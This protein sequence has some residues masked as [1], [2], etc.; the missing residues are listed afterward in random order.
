MVA[1]ALGVLHP[2]RETA[3]L[4]KL[5]SAQIK[6]LLINA[7]QTDLVRVFSGLNDQ[8]NYG[9]NVL[10]TRDNPA[11]VR[12]ER[13]PFPPVL[14]QFRVGKCRAVFLKLLDVH[15]RTPFK[16]ATE[17]GAATVQR[18]RIVA[19]L[20]T[21]IPASPRKH[22]STKKDRVNPPSNFSRFPLW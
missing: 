21:A 13:D 14:E 15:D 8:L 19:R 11:S 20:S 9:A 22:K 16:V 18:S 3:S 6:V 4:E 5:R 10:M 12:A 2:E 7:L 17:N 1:A